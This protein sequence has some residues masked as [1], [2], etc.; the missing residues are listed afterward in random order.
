MNVINKRLVLELN[1]NWLPINIISW[2]EAFIKICKNR[3][4]AIDT[5]GPNGEVGTYE[6]LTMDQWIE[7][8]SKLE[9]KQ[10][11]TSLMNLPIPEIIVS[12]GYED[13][14]DR[15]ITFCKRN[16]MIRDNC[17]CAYCGCEL[18]EETATVDHVLP[19]CLGG[20]DVWS[21][22]VIACRSCNNQKDNNPPKGRWAPRFIPRE[23]YK[24]NPIYHIN[25]DINQGRIQVPDSWRRALFMA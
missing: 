2:K 1:S 10:V 24:L 12:T 15:T 6:P 23:P 4:K 19:R 14:P 21:N 16:I 25:I 11:G 17:T 20:Q 3:S 7:V 18:N 5:N 22:V 13:M 9:Y 8:H